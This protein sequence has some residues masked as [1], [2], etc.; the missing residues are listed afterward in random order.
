MTKALNVVALLF[1]LFLLGCGVAGG[2]L[3]LRDRATPSILVASL[4]VS[5][6]IRCM[7]GSVANLRRAS[8]AERSDGTLRLIIYSVLVGL[9]VLMLSVASD[10]V[11]GN[12]PPEWVYFGS[13]L[14][15]LLPSLAALVFLAVRALAGRSGA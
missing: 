4:F 1:G 14:T 13:A 9:S 12:A 2:F 6:G 15:M 5:V 8:T 11:L 10:A 3:A 7:A